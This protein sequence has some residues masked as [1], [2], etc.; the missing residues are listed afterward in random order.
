MGRL[1]AHCGAYYGLALDCAYVL[2]GYKRVLSLSLSFCCLCRA[3]VV[4][5]SSVVGVVVRKGGVYVL[6][7]SERVLYLSMSFVACCEMLV[8]IATWSE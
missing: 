7:G 4:S 1:A 6:F 5:D 8:W 2:L 3:D